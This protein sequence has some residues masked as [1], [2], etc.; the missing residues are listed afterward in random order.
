MIPWRWWRARRGIPR[1]NTGGIP[2]DSVIEGSLEIHCPNVD[3]F[4]MKK[5]DGE[6]E[7][8]QGHCKDKCFFKLF[9]EQ[10]PNFK[11]WLL[12]IGMHH[13][14]STSWS[15]QVEKSCCHLDHLNPFGPTEIFTPGSPM[16]LHFWIP[17]GRSD[18]VSDFRTISRSGRPRPPFCGDLPW[19]SSARDKRDD[20][21]E[22]IIIQDPAQI[23][24]ILFKYKIWDHFWIPQAS[25]ECRLKKT[26]VA[27][28][29][30]PPP[31]SPLR[32]WG[33]HGIASPG[34]DGRLCSADGRIMF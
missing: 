3:V 25:N 29:H 1:W 33:S 9:L 31:T 11:L 12:H 6:N 34:G 26:E 20:D 13:D 8:T 24:L 14:P 2:F 22:R 5:Q 15:E 19:T 27:D 21:F 7:T 16:A 10:V 32:R 23:Y 28:I 18:S 4:P 30:N 17:S